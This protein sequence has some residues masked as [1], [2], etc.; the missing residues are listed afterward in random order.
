MTRR[1]NVDLSA[2]IARDPGWPVG[3]R[4]RELVLRFLDDAPSGTAVRFVVAAAGDDAEAS[5]PQLRIVSPDAAAQLVVGALTSAAHALGDA[6]PIA[7]LDSD[8]VW[9]DLDGIS[10]WHADRETLYSALKARAVVIVSCISAT[11]LVVEVAGSDVEC[12]A[13]ERNLAAVRSHA[14]LAVFESRALE[15]EFLSLGAGATSSRALPTVVIRPAGDLRESERPTVDE[16]LNPDLL[17]AVASEDGSVDLETTMAAFAEV[18]RARRS[19]KLIV[20]VASQ[21]QAEQVYSGSARF[22]RTARS[23]EVVVAPSDDELGALYRRSALTIYVP[24]LKGRGIV[25]AQSLSHGCLTISTDSRVIR[26]AGGGLIDYVHYHEATEVAETA[27]MYLGRPAL[28]AARTA[29]IMAEY[30]PRTWNLHF[31]TLS[32]ILENLDRSLTVRR[33]PV[34]DQLQFVLI[35]NVPSSLA[36]TI[37]L[38]EKYS[39]DLIKEFVV[40]SP[41][42]MHSEIGAIGSRR[43]MRLIDER[44][45]LGDQFEEFRSADHQRKNWMLRSTIL[46]VPDIDDAFVMLD[47]D[48]QPLESFDASRFRDPDGR[49]RG[50]YYYDIA[51][52]P[53]KHTEYDAGQNQT[54]EVLADLGFELLSYSSHQPQILITDVFA[55]VVALT[56]KVAPHT[57]LD[58]W[59]IYF[60]FLASRYP[61]LLNKQVFISM[62]WPSSPSAWQHRYSPAAFGFEN[63]YPEAYEPGGIFEGLEL[64]TDLAEKNAR[65]AAELAPWAAARAAFDSYRAPAERDHLARGPLLIDDPHVRMVVS[66]IPR[67]IDSNARLR[68]TF[69]ILDKAEPNVVQLCYRVLGSAFSIGKGVEF[70]PTGRLG[71]HSGT[72]E[73]LFESGNLAPG[74]YTIEFFAILGRRILWPRR[75]RYLTRLVV[76]AESTTIEQELLHDVTPLWR[77]KNFVYRLRSARVLNLFRR[78]AHGGRGVTRT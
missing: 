23:V 29:Q 40:I 71:S 74:T 76:L 9:L 60:N 18:H 56:D 12:V 1:I 5:A 73:F 37:P 75:R 2:I 33:R 10:H 39:G 44:E 59:S 69:N 27:L 66:G 70:A 72:V 42:S 19:T 25:P 20:T 49:Y 32:T 11:D 67:V 62:N 7:D 41:P 3:R 22:G 21:R 31:S 46:R 53:H 43:P 47:D 34:Q 51:E 8:D 54:A 63:Y 16:A 58:E 78:V 4:E 36:R 38:L 45:L 64:G 65:K 13:R 48:N 15:L 50:Y 35:S 24:T 14:D 61:L 26:E 57:S 55:E 17:L 6:L 68:L 30:R 52:W 77:A 28:R